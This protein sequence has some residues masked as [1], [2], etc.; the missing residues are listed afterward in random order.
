MKKPREPWWRLL[1]PG[2][3][4][5]ASDNDPTTVATLAVIGS[6][7]VYALGWL[8]ILVIPMLAAVQAISGRVGAVCGEG[9]ETILKNRYGRIVALVVLVAVFVVD[10]LT[11][12]ADLEGG[13]AALQ[14]LSGI[15]YRWFIVPLAAATAATLTFANYHAVRRFLIYIPL[16]F[17]SYVAAAFMAHP[18]WRAVL[19]DTFVPH[20]SFDRTFTAGVIALLGTTLTAYAYVWET[21]EMSEERPK[22]M[23]LGL[24]QADAALGT[25][26]AGFVFWFIVIATG[27]T[28]GLQHHQVQT[29][30]D[31][32]NALAPLAGRW[33]SAVFGIGL[34]G[35][36]IIAL[37]VLAG[38][39]AYVVAEMFDWRKGIDAKFQQAPFF[40][41]VVIA[42][43]AIGVGIT[44]AG[45]QPIPLLFAASIAGGLATPITLFFVLLAAGST[46][47][48]GAFRPPLWLRVAGWIVFAIVSAAAI[49]YLRQVV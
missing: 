32:A 29:A 9:L 23:H 31:A 3:I 34:L 44:F 2:I 8:V 18:Q 28:L 24:V 36:S 37:P 41:A 13:G 10:Q 12:A 20:F 35:S 43:L 38:T 30:Q 21:I 19:Y 15:D 39:S 17:L 46:Q 7:T 26:I 25:V 22:L 5:G 11:L 14:L 48:M 45:V 49:L 27:A 6:T 4:S 42:T 1:G 33:A 40:Y 47:L 16:V